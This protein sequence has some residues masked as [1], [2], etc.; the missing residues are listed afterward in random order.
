MAA[1]TMGMFGAAATPG[2]WLWCWESS[3][4]WAE[5]PQL[6]WAFATPLA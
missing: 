3:L 2:A 5:H 1:N 6:A 4:S